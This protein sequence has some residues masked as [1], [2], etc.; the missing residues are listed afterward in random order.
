MAHRKDLGRLL[1]ARNGLGLLAV[2]VCLTACGSGST[3][4]RSE[5]SVGS[6]PP[7]VSQSFTHRMR[8]LHRVLDYVERN[9]HWRDVERTVIDDGPSETCEGSPLDGHGVPI[10]VE[11][12]LTVALQGV[13]ASSDQAVPF[14]DAVRAFTVLLGSAATDVSPTRAFF[15]RNGYA[16][17]V[18]VGRL[19]RVTIG[20]GFGCLKRGT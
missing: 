3:T 17:S 18:I 5:H 19:G 2:I 13:T 7:G 14:A 10:F 6:S 12:G 11:G 20:G 16:F 1:M 4:I 15:K 8:E 9:I